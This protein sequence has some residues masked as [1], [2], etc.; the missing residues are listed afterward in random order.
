MF[1]SFNFNQFFAL[2][3][4]YAVLTVI[5]QIYLKPISKW[6]GMQSLVKPKLTTLVT[7]SLLG[8][9][10]LTMVI[11]GYEAVAVFAISC[12]VD[13]ILACIRRKAIVTS[14]MSAFEDPARPLNFN[15]INGKAL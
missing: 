7:S 11:L 15:E 3:A 14:V 2:L 4:I 1:E 13:P 5:V 6:I 10:V 9:W 12:V 8:V